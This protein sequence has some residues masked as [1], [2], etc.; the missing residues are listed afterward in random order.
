M[1]FNPSLN[2]SVI[3]DIQQSGQ[4]LQT[5][6]QQVAT[7]QRVNLPS[8]NPAAVATLVQLQTQSANVDQ[9]TANAGTALS[10]AHSADAVLSSVVSLLNQAV[11][12]GTEGA[13]NSSSSP[14]ERASLT[15]SVQGILSSIV[16]LANTTFEGMSLFGGTTN[17]TAAFTPDPTSA[18]GY[19]YN[20]NSGVNYIPVGDSLAVQA[21]IPGD[22]LFTNTQGSVLGALNNLATALTTGTSAS[23]GTATTAI[24]SALNFVTVQQAVYGNTINQLSAQE[25]SLSQEKITLTSQQ[26]SL[27]GIDPA[28]AAENLSQAETYN[29]SVLAAAA[30]VLQNTLLNYLK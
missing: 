21:N 8:D 9:Y 30:R 18:T 24:T 14:V 5:A 10:Q 13:N 26:N 17:G 11:T 29:S 6:L 16:S 28:T 2:A 27:V 1:R 12:L 23:I 15:A 19:K 7:G 22:T 3:Q 20:G 25:T 4:N